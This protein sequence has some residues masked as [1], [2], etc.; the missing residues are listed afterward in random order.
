MTGGQRTV[1]P[2]TI[3]Q[4]DRQ[5]DPEHRAEVRDAALTGLVMRIRARLAG[6]GTVVP[7]LVI[8]G[9]G[10]DG[11]EKVVAE[12]S[13]LARQL[14]NPVIFLVESLQKSAG[15]LLHEPDSA[16]LALR[17]SDRADAELVCEFIGRETRW[18]V[19]QET[20]TRGESYE[21][22]WARQRGSGTSTGTQEADNNP[23]GSG[24]ISNG[25]SE[26]FGTTVSGGKGANVSVGTA[27]TLREDILV[28]KP[29]VITS[30]PITAG[31]LVTP[32]ADGTVV[33][34]R[35]RRVEWIDCDPRAPFASGPE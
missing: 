16:V 10:D 8:A 24:N 28:V 35:P 17:M 21:Q 31:F 5:L 30:L 7:A 20:H 29:E 6:V 14:P 26:S 25:T 4:L 9:L 23:F 27:R 34:A 32:T 13:A 3:V 2:C 19:T 11:D 22:G 12:L 18:D 33:D 1:D 15:R